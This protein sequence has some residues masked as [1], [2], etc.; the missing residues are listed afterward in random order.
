MHPP[1]PNPTHIKSHQPAPSPS[2]QAINAGADIIDCSFAK[3]ELDR[4]LGIHAFS[5]DRLLLNDPE[6][7]VRGGG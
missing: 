1:H 5:L 2:P 6:F 4:V 7:L 3:V